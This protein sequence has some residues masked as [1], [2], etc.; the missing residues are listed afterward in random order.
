MFVAGR[1]T[2]CI[3]SVFHVCRW[4]PD[5]SSTSCSASHIAGVQW[6]SELVN[7]Q[8]SHECPLHK[9]MTL[10]WPLIYEKYIEKTL[11]ILYSS[12]S[13]ASLTARSLIMVESNMGTEWFFFRRPHFGQLPKPASR[14]I[15][16][17]VAQDSINKQVFFFFKLKV[18]KA[19]ATGRKC[20]RIFFSN[21]LLN[22][23]R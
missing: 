8:A 5:V 2:F 11:Q 20:S 18:Y 17:H 6:I 3:S 16:P 13:K 14:V 1:R 23:W 22:H 9:T 19:L 10:K 7:W 12:G 21:F 4:P 15:T